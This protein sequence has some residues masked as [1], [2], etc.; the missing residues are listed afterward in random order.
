MVPGHVAFC[1]H[2]EHH[3]PRE[4]VVRRFVH[5]LR[6]RSISRHRRIQQRAVCVRRT[7]LEPT[8]ERA[9]EGERK[10]TDDLATPSAPDFGAQN[11]TLRPWRA[12]EVFTEA[13]PSA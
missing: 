5:F 6:S 13:Y 1:Q 9:C 12:F 3:K 8:L 2:V 4:K 10:A 11:E 7:G